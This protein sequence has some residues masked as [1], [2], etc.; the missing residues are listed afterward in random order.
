MSPFIFAGLHYDSFEAYTF[1]FTRDAEVELD[2]GI[3]VGL[4][5]QIAR[6]VKN[7]RRAGA[8]GL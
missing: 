6:G 7:R 1:K 3:G 8:V 4:V 5:E 2:S